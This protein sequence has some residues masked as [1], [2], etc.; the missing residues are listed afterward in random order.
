MIQQPREKLLPLKQIFQFSLLYID[1]VKFYSLLQKFSL[2]II[3]LFVPKPSFITF[4]KRPNPI[5]N[6]NLHI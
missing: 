5:H 6:R 1:V 4:C 3:I 2:S